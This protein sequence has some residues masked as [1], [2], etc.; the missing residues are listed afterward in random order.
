ML[1][2]IPLSLAGWAADDVW[3]TDFDQAKQQAAAS[4]KYI[5]I[6]FTG[7]DWCG[8]CKRLDQEVFSQSEFTKFAADNLIL[9]KLDYPRYRQQSQAEKQ[10][11]AALAQQFRVQGF[12]TLFLT[13]ASGKPVLQTGYQPGGP[14]PFNQLLKSKMK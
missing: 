4:G 2:L 13:D 11:N 9:L 6:N 12:P 3:L 5:L 14:Q 8:W 1:I 10:R 7:S